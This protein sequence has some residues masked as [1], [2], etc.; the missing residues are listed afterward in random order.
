[1]LKS[2]RV[3]V[4]AC[5]AA[6]YALYGHWLA[7]RYCGGDGRLY[8][9]GNAG[10]LRGVGGVYSLNPVSVSLWLACHLKIIGPVCRGEVF[11]GREL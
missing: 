11:K 6:G 1:M 4:R 5:R 9:R 3:C 8:S 7:A 2:K 10:K